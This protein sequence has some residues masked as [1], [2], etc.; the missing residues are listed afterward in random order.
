MLLISEVDRCLI[1][2]SNQVITLGSRE[3]EEVRK[4]FAQILAHCCL[5]VGHRHMGTLI[6][7]SLLNCY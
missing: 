3:K 2:G 6:G 1:A 7:Y 4:F 5:F